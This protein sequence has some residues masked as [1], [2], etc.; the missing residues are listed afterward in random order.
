MSEIDGRPKMFGDKAKCLGDGCP[1]L[2]RL[3]TAG[4]DIPAAIEAARQAAALP[5]EFCNDGMRTSRPDRGGNTWR[6]CGTRQEVQAG[7]G[8]IAA[9]AEM[10]AADASV[11]VPAIATE[12]AL[13]PAAA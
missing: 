2:G 13:E 6:Y 4:I 10:Q 3:A 1:M 9:Y 12:A 7:V 8:A 5:Y 11:E